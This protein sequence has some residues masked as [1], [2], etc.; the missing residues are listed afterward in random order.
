MDYSVQWQY[1]Q[2][3]TRD[4]AKPFEQLLC[5]QVGWEKVA[6]LL[7]SDLANQYQNMALQGFKRTERYF[8]RDE[9]EEALCLSRFVVDHLGLVPDVSIN[10]TTP[11]MATTVKDLLECKMTYYAENLDRLKRIIELCYAGG[12]YEFAKF[13]GCMISGQEDNLVKLKRC[14]NELAFVGW[15][16]TFMMMRSDDL[17]CKFKKKEEKKQGRMIK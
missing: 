8:S 16:N 15:D 2:G 14:Y 10:Y 3:Y 9:M 17:H 12:R 7:C 6:G 5:E 4:T 13:I 11:P 1:G